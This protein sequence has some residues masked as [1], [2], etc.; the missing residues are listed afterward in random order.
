MVFSDGHGTRY[1]A[2]A[3]RL[4]GKRWTARVYEWT[5]GGGCEIWRSKDTYATAE[6]AV[7]A[8][9]PE[10]EAAAERSRKACDEAAAGMADLR[11][12]IGEWFGSN[13]PEVESIQFTDD[14]GTVRDEIVIPKGLKGEQ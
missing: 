5:E 1:E 7:E 3:S 2:S 10:A 6:D 11:T 14:D 9:N 12:A 4:H 13:F 8:A